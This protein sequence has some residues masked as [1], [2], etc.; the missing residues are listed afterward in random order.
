MTDLDELERL[1]KAA[2]PGPWEYREADGSAAV[3]HR[4]GWVEAI[5]PGSPQEN[6]DAA[7]CAAANPAT[8]LAL[9]A[10]VRRLRADLDGAGEMANKNALDAS[11]WQHIY[12]GPYVVCRVHADGRLEN[13][14]GSY[15]GKYA[16]DDGMAARAAHPKEGA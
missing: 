16:V 4:G 7:Y 9:T 1:A 12:H 2:T 6:S 8:I 11:R 14:G 15:V 13:L 10:E 5:L 3:C